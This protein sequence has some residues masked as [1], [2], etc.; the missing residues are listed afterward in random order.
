MVTNGQEKT[1]RS[2]LT[3]YMCETWGQPPGAPRGRVIQLGDEL[4]QAVTGGVNL[5]AQI[6][7]FTFE[8]AGAGQ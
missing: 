6:G 5:R 3:I 1:G 8:R 4:Q 2:G 7:D